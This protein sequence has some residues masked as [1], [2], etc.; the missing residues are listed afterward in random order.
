MADV[1]QQELANLHLRLERARALH[2]H[3]LALDILR[4]IAELEHPDA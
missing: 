3:D 4:A 2:L 1:D